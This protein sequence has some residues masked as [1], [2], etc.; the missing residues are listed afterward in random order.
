MFRAKV[1]LTMETEC[2]LSEVTSRWNDA[3]TVTK[4]EVLDDE[5]I[6]FLIDGGDH[7]DDLVAAF[8]A[9][10]QVRE[11]ERID[12]TRLALTKRSC[13]AL[14]VI[15]SN[16]GML[17]GF[18]RVS[19]AQRVFDIVVFRRR[20]L[21]EIVAGLQEVG[22]VRLGRLT[23][24]D[25]PESLLSGRQS[26]VLRAALE[27]GYYEWPRDRDAKSIA[28]D[29]DIAHSTFLEHLRK[30]ERTLLI[31]ALSRNGTGDAGAPSEEAFV[32][33]ATPDGGRPTQ[34]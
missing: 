30:A 5:Y 31:D 13:G 16:H 26:E 2:I 33:G 15:R 28:A 18:D 27:A 17:Q 12:G 20:D 9:S 10:D 25:T 34:E 21:R 4:E 8:E 6:R 1:F 11:I 23:P 14:P 22:S 29:L 32:R 24:F 3:F 19:G 7:A